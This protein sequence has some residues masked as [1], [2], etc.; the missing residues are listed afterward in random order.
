MSCDGAWSTGAVVLGGKYRG[1]REQEATP[2][3]LDERIDGRFQW[4][5]PRVI[6]MLPILTPRRFIGILEMGRSPG[7]VSQIQMANSS[8][9]VV[10][11]GIL[12]ALCKDSGPRVTSTRWPEKDLESA[13]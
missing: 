6:G 11:S 8:E 2:F 1:V 4:G 7:N 5:D 12:F 10:T 9:C 3:C 13:L